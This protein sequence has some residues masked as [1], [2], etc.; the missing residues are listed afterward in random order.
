[1]TAMK[2]RRW[3]R[4]GLNRK[5][6]PSSPGFLEAV[7]GRKIYA[8]RKMIGTSV[9]GVFVCFVLYLDVA[10]N[11]L[12]EAKGAKVGA[13]IAH[14]IVAAFILITFFMIVATIKG[15]LDDRDP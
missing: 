9:F 15:L 1:M 5:L 6:A 2:D 13:P 7:L 11:G 4:R 3:R 12:L 14:A 10:E 8:Q